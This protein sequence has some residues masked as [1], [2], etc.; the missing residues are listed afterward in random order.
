MIGSGALITTE[1]VTVTCDGSPRATA[2]KM[3]MS[4]TSPKTNRVI[5]RITP[6]PYS[7]RSRRPQPRRWPSP[8]KKANPSYFQ[9]K[10]LQSARQQEGG[11]ADESVTTNNS[12]VHCI[13]DFGGFGG[14]WQIRA[15]SVY[16]RPRLLGGHRRLCGAGGR[17]SFSRR[18]ASARPPG[19]TTS[20][21]LTLPPKH[22]CGAAQA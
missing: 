5:G 8:S 19:V 15:N 13:A 20:G 18:L 6:P 7:S 9:Q 2:A 3:P 12:G 11:A 4:T 1:R 14:D 16:Y 21:G 17:Q 22:R 10:R